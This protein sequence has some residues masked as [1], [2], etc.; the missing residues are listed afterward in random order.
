VERGRVFPLI[1][2][3][4]RGFGIL[5]LLVSVSLDVLNILVLLAAPKSTAR[6]EVPRAS[7]LESASVM[8]ADRQPSHPHPKVTECS[9]FK[10]PNPAIY[11]SANLKRVESA[12]PWVNCLVAC[13]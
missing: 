2:S 13:T 8:I 7:N 12:L 5:G 1:A 6:G 11:P 3:R 9:L 10:F 4:H